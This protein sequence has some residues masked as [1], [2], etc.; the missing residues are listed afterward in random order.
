MDLTRDQH[1][2]LRNV[3]YDNMDKLSDQFDE[4][5]STWR[6]RRPRNKLD[7]LLQKLND[8]IHLNSGQHPCHDD[9]SA[10]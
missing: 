3:A 7:V 1:W 6:D 2:Q 5:S 4:M 10:S 9:V 8:Y